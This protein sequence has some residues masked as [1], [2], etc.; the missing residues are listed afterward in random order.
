MSEVCHHSNSTLRPI[1]RQ[2]EKILLNRTHAARDSVIPTLLCLALIL[3][4]AAYARPGTA[5]IESAFS[6]DRNAEDLVVRTLDGARQTIRLAAYSFTSPP[7][8]RALLDAKKRGVDVRVVVD[9]RGNKSKASIAAINLIV[10]AHI[11]TRTISVY[12]IHHDKYAVIDAL[13]VQT[14]SF[15]YSKAA[16]KSNSENVIVVRD[17]GTAL[18]FMQHWQSRWAQGVDAVSGY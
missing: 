1:R 12:A 4:A 15:N 8:V 6:P 2:H 17:A 16:A 13:T 3:P 10:N 9:S 11:P 14:G 5:V 7:V 18:A